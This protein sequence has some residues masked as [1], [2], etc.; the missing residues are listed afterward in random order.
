MNDGLAALMLASTTGGYGVVYE[1]GHEFAT[2]HRLMGIVPVI[3]VWGHSGTSTL[4]PRVIDLQTAQEYV[5]MSDING[6]AGTERVQGNIADYRV[7]LH[8]DD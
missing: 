5:S 4:Q 3:S 7:K 1:R 6:I 8:G 2:K